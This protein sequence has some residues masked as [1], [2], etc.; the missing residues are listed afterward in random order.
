MGNLSSAAVRITCIHRA[1]RGKSTFPPGLFTVF[2]GRGV[3]KIFPKNFFTPEELGRWAFGGLLLATLGSW[4]VA[5]WM[6]LAG[7]LLDFSNGVTISPFFTGTSI[8]F[9]LI[10]AFFNLAFFY[11][12]VPEKFK[13]WF[14]PFCSVLALTVL[15]C[16]YFFGK[17]I[18]YYTFIAAFFWL[19][20]LVVFHK[21][22][23][24]V[25]P[26][27][28][29]WTFV[30]LGVQAFY[31]VIDGHY[32]LLNLL[33]AEIFPVTFNV[34][35]AG[36][37]TIWGAL[38]CLW[39]LYS[40]ND[41]CKKIFSRSN[42]AM[43]IVFPVSWII[44][45]G[46]AF[47]EERTCQRNVV[48]TKEFFG[49]PLTADGLRNFYYK[50]APGNLDFWE[51]IEQLSE[52]F[53]K[54]TA[55]R[56]QNGFIAFPEGKFDKKTMEA[57][58][59][60]LDASP[61]IKEITSLFSHKLPPRQREFKKYRLGCITLDELYLLRQVSRLQAWRMRFA[62]EKNDMATAVEALECINKS[63]D[64]SDKDFV[65]IS[66]LLSHSLLE[67]K[68]NV[69]GL[70]LE[71]GQL[72]PHEIKKQ[73]DLLIEK[74]KHLA[75]MERTALGGEIAVAL[76]FQDGIWEGETWLPAIKKIRWFVPQYWYI[77]K[78]SNNLFIETY[79]K[80]S[81]KWD[82]LLYRHIM[83][84]RKGYGDH[85]PGRYTELKTMYLL[86]ETL[87][88]LELEKRKIGGY[89]ES[90]PEWLPLDPFTGRKFHYK[91]GDMP[92]LEAVHDPKTNQLRTV[93]RTVKAVALWSEGVNRKNDQG[94]KS[95][96]KN[97]WDDIRVMIR[98]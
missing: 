90:A 59:N 92:I 77:I 46:A 48:Q 38:F 91:K 4:S 18:G 79:Q 6:T 98:L 41:H 22:S 29:C 51:K 28:A 70:L 25:I 47:C 87:L 85:V 37:F 42:V 67:L 7:R 32:R 55:D 13:K 11:S 24:W 45:T 82:P 89:P 35:L 23:H 1:L 56:K 64:R 50:E 49:F 2:Q 36:C 5:A 72:E 60:T 80:N 21:D 61:Q 39:Q 12:C 30:F 86:L 16:G 65:L 15:G 3:M 33:Q 71:N 44:M 73:L 94:L 75:A 96:R 66:H 63:I 8:L 31:E 27:S 93:Q 95:R 57:W 76:D 84:D 9:V 52:T 68:K 34:A 20:P 43:L 58:K 74:R 53:S 62:L 78:H 14:F 54:Q 10:A 26:G 40:G 81:F 83:F 17:E 97:N 69:V 19:L 88:K